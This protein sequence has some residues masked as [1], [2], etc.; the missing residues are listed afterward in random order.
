MAFSSGEVQ[1][2]KDAL[3]AQTIGCA[4]CA[5][6]NW[7]LFDR[8]LCLPLFDLEYKQI[9][10]GMFSVVVQITCLNCSTIRFIAANKLGIV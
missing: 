2:I 1:K 8:P 6:K 7:E 9:V 10:E 4:S 5:S 3:D